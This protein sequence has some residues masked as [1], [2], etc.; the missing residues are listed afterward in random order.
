M[1]EIDRQ[2]D[3]RRACIL[4]P[5]FTL[6]RFKFKIRLSCNAP[7]TPYELLAINKINHAKKIIIFVDSGVA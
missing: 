1:I 7:S 3:R 2:T 4:V 6:K 5:A